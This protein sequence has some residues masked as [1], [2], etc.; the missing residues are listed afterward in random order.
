MKISRELLICAA[1]VIAASCSVKETLPE[2]R[3]ND[4]KENAERFAYVFPIG[5]EITRA[6]LS[7]ASFN[8]EAG[9]DRIGIFVSGKDSNA[10]ASVSEGA[11]AIEASLENA[12]QT[13]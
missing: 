8:W 1:A 3:I 12:R 5:R 7:G 11:D 9:E 6:S 10:P 4:G 13:A 2:P